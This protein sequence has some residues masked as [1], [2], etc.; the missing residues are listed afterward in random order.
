MSNETD[1]QR[2]RMDIYRAEL[3]ERMSHAVSKDKVIEAFPGLLISSFVESYAKTS[4][5]FH[6]CLLCHRAG[7]KNRAFER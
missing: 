6:A 2:Q 5:G 4:F 1:F 7:R 3:V